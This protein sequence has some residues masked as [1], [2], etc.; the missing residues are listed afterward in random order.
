VEG[1]RRSR[2]WSLISAT[3]VSGGSKGPPG[4]RNSRRFDV[5]DD[6]GLR[7]LGEVHH[8]RCGRHR[9]LDEPG[10][11]GALGHRRGRQFRHG[12]LRERPEPLAQFDSAG[13]FQYICTPHPFMKGTIHVNAAGG[14]GSGFGDSG[15]GSGGSSRTASGT[16]SAPASRARAPPAP[17]R[18][19]AP[20][21]SCPTPTRTSRPL[22]FLGCLCSLSA[23]RYSAGRG[24][25]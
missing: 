15:S 10:R 2:A 25:T 8:D 11:R 19:R 13:T 17:A 1:R 5:G 9:D 22:R 18:A 20:A 6:E 23:W 16:S 3:I 14:G 24:R 4:G 21:P 12:H 7:V